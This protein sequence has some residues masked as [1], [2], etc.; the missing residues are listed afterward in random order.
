MAKKNKTVRFGIKNVYYTLYD[1]ST[2][3]YG[4]PKHVDGAVKLSITPEGDTS[5][6]YAEDILWA[7]FESVSGY[8][9]TLEVAA[10]NDEFLNDVLGRR[11][12]SAGLAYETIDDEPKQF[13]LL[14]EVS[15]NKEPQRYVYYNVV[16]S[17]VEQEHNTKSDSTTPDTETM[18]ITIASQAFTV[19]D[20]EVET[21]GGH[22][23]KSA[24]TA[25]AYAD[26]F[27]S[28]TVPTTAAASADE[29]NGSQTE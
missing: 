4:T 15:S 20:E 25:T 11:T 14:Y 22:I 8:T 5:N 2:G 12:D 27:K 17:R 9:G 13:A 1:D 3:K 6:F 10:F 24:E 28:V 7:S 16:G 19:G 18:D 26:W 21:I 29:G 23:T